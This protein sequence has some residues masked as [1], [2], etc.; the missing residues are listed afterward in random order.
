MQN[1][2]FIL[3]FILRL[4]YWV[5]VLWVGHIGFNILFNSGNADTVIRYYL[6]TLSGILIIT[7]ALFQIYIALLYRQM[8]GYDDGQKYLLDRE[9]Y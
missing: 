6:E 1:L 3:F 9:K 5:F 7:V 4:C 2:V 8:S